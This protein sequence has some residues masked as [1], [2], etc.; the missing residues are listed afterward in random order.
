M[1][2]LVWLPDHQRAVAN[3]VRNERRLC[4]GDRP[5]PARS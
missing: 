4:R 1:T 3:A 2:P 5:H